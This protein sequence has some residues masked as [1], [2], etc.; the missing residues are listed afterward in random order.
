MD[1]PPRLLVV[2]LEGTCCRDDSIPREERETIEI[3]AVLVDGETLAPTDEF[4]TFV[5][6]IA[7]PTLTPF[8]LEL[9][10]ITQSDVDGA[11]G[12]PS[13]F[14]RLLAWTGPGDARFC[15]WGGYDRSQFRRDCARHGVENPLD[16]GHLNLKERFSEVLG[17]RPHFGMKRALELCGLPL[18]GTHHRGLDDA[19]NIARM[20]PFLLGE[21]P[22]PT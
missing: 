22:L 12:F 3:G 9:T 17:R 20:L 16:E 14:A 2:D 5:R 13:A 10:S 8:C 4:Q 21:R 19:R 1:R 18:E 6:P 15:S 7:H 11:E